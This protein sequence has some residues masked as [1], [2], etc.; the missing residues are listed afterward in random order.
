[1]CVNDRFRKDW[2]VYVWNYQVQYRV[3]CVSAELTGAVK[4]GLCE[5]VELRSTV[6]CGPC[7][8]GNNRFSKE[9][10]V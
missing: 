4:S 6:R 1:M 2:A 7:E 3:S 10:G 9:W 8:S 5:C